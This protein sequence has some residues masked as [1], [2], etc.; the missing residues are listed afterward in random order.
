MGSSFSRKN[1]NVVLQEQLAKDPV[2]I[3]SKSTCPACIKTRQLLKDEKIPA[4]FYELNQM[5]AGNDIFKAVTSKTGWSTV[6]QIFICGKFVGGFS[7]L[8]AL[9]SAGFLSLMVNE[10]YRGDLY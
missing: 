6:P 1:M 4:Q 8:M 3:Y 10:C 7:E 9:Q 5:T 2:V